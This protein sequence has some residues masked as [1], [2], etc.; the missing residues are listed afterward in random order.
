[1][2]HRNELRAIRVPLGV[3][4]AQFAAYMGVPLRTYEDLESGKTSIRPVH[5]NAA[6]RAA[7]Q[8]ALDQG[9]PDLLSKP[10]IDLVRKL[11]ALASN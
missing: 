7:M 10:L 4:Q 8:A 1:M 6:E 3:T 2:A 9:D 5:I 11:A